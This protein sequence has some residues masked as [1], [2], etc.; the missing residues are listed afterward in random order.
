MHADTPKSTSDLMLFSIIEN[1]LNEIQFRAYVWLFSY[2]IEKD[3]TSQSPYLLVWSYGEIG[4]YDHMVV[5]STC[6]MQVYKFPFDVLSCNL[7]FRSLLHSG[8]M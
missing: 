3:K 6:R 1:T 4:L 7:S 2:R 8:E 5:I